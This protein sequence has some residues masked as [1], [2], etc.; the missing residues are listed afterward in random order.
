METLLT[1]RRRDV[2]P[3]FKGPAGIPLGVA[4]TYTSQQQSIDRN[5]IV[6][7]LL[8][9]PEID[10]GAAVEERCVIVANAIYLL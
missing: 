7:S 4:L 6:R 9:H 2:N 5:A 1:E 3:N 8:G 10:T